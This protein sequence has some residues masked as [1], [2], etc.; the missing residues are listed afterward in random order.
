LEQNVVQ[1]TQMVQRIWRKPC[2]SQYFRTCG[3]FVQNS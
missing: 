1:E 2:F 3:L